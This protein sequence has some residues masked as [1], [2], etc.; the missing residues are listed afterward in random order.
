MSIIENKELYLATNDRYYEIINFDC[1]TAV[2]TNAAEDVFT[3]AVKPFVNEQEQTIDGSEFSDFF[4]LKSALQYSIQLKEIFSKQEIAERT[5][6]L[7]IKNKE[8]KKAKVK[9]QPRIKI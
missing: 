6:K 2:L 4:D 7:E 9:S 3:V 5:E 8:I 1:D